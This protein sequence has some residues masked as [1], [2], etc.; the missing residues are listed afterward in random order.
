M[1]YI[2]EYEELRN[3]TLAEHM[4][5]RLR[6]MER[7]SEKIKQFVRESINRGFDRGI[8]EHALPIYHTKVTEMI[9]IAE[10][11]ISASSNSGKAA[12]MRTEISTVKSSLESFI[13]T[14]QNLVM[15]VPTQTENQ[16]LFTRRRR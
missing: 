11:A 13:K 6:E 10:T 7:Y 14:I 5:I 16:R 8:V 4:L 1:D 2:K 12:I 3:E 9:E 15:T